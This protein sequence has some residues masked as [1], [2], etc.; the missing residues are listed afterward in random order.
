MPRCPPVRGLFCEARAAGE[1]P[2]CTHV[3]NLDSACV[4]GRPWS[5]L[6]HDCARVRGACRVGLVRAAPGG[7][8]GGAVLRRETGSGTGV[9]GTGAFLSNTRCGFSRFAPRWRARRRRPRRPRHPRSVLPGY[10]FRPGAAW[11]RPSLPTTRI[12]CSV[13]PTLTLSHISA[14][15]KRG[16]LSVLPLG[17]V[18]G[19]VASCVVPSTSDLLPLVLGEIAELQGDRW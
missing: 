10:S 6:W 2:R 9:C 7:S 13:G 5:P 1:W 15:T 11:P 12:F 19:G 8:H 18:R 14:R 3:T 16:S 4:S 17:R